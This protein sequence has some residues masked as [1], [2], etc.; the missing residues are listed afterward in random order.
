MLLMRVRDEAHR[1]VNTFHRKRRTKTLIR[2]ALDDVP[3]IG[4][5]KRQALLEAFGSVKALLAATDTDIASI[6]GISTKDVERIRAHFREKEIGLG[7]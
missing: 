5:K 7:A 2:S 1:F 6:P 3:S 4:P